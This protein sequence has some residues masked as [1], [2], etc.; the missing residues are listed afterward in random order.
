MMPDDTKRTIYFFTALFY[1]A[2]LFSCSRS[3][4]V[5]FND[6]HIVYEGRV[7]KK[8]DAAVLM[9]SGTAV[10]IN[11]K[12][13]GISGIFKESDTANYY[14]VFIDSQLI[15]VVHFDTIVK[16]YVL[17]NDL[18]D[19]AHTLE[20][21]KR[22]AWDKG[23]VFFYGFVF[24]NAAI[25]LPPTEQPARK[26]E[27][28]GNSI[29]CGYGVED[30]SNDLGIGFFENSYN[31]YAAIT[32]RHFNAQAHYTVKSGIGITISWFPLL[33]KEMYSRL[34]ATN[35]NSKW[36]FSSYIPDVVVINLLQNDYWLVKMPEHAEFK[37]NFG[38]KAPDSVF[39][40]QQYKN[41]VQLVRQQYPQAKII[42]MLGNMSITENGS[43]WPSYVQT[44]VDAMHDKNIFTL[45]VP[46]KETPGHP[47]KEEQKILA[48]ALINFIKKNIKW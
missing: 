37:K 41:F 8:N 9:W 33:M 21:Y 38:S 22:T 46:Y 23:K 40:I 12:G 1:V 13:T 44:A 28:F 42:C 6:A 39:I 19:T 11:F 35:P 17:A 15:R 7:A 30:N 34:D 25:L 43:P 20:L 47:N 29:T 10:K 3:I 18:K 27:F 2:A 16:T 24:S 14:N 4:T 32:A 26:I 36:S 31:T 45:F 5:P 48:Q